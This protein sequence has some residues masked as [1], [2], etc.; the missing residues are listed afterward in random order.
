M[1]AEGGWI[2]L[3]DARLSDIACVNARRSPAIQEVENRMRYTLGARARIGKDLDARWAAGP[4]LLTMPG[5]SSCLAT[6]LLA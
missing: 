3:V 2:D 4:P 6:V 1:L 5:S